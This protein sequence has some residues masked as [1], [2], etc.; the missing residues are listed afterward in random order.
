MCKD[1]YGI[2][3]E[4]IVV[5]EG[6]DL[7]LTFSTRMCNYQESFMVGL[8]FEL[9]LKD[10][11]FKDS[12]DCIDDEYN[13]E[14]ITELVLGFVNTFYNDGDLVGYPNHYVISDS[15]FSELVEK[16]NVFIN[17]YLSVTIRNYQEKQYAFTSIGDDASVK[18]K[19]W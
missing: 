1:G 4:G 6:C 8:D 19:C 2:G 18:F 14:T 13:K 16:G 9:E 11:S 12:S 15:E 7:Q 10:G 3:K 17:G 5:N